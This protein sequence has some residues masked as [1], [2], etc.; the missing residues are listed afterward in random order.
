[1]TQRDRWT[2]DAGRLVSTPIPPLP[3]MPDI[4]GRQKIR[5]RDSAEHFV[6]LNALAPDLLVVHPQ[7]FA[8]GYRNASPDLLARAAVAKMLVEAAKL[9]PR[10]LKL[11]IWDAW[12]PTALQKELFDEE[13]EKQRARNPG[14]SE[15]EVFRETQRFVSVPSNDPATPA[16]HLTG[17]AIDLTICR[18]DGV[19][20]EM[21]TPVDDFSEKAG[22]RYFEEQAVNGV[23][24]DADRLALEH[25]RLLHGVMTTVGFTAYRDE[26]WHFDYGDQ[27][28]AATLN[29]DSIYAGRDHGGQ[30]STVAS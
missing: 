6:C 7:Y 19:P 29:V 16:P 30:G 20:I 4:K 26:W 15:E 28:W 27:F 13:F 11:L 10:S 2:G 3:K 22:T 23:L 1:M 17:G 8:R 14:Y 5:I 21:G 12:R 18:A 9:L 25:R 24:A